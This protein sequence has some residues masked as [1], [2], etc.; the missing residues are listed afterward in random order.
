MRTAWTSV[1]VAG[2]AVLIVAA[3]LGTLDLMAAGPD[4][5]MRPQPQATIDVYELAEAIVIAQGIARESEQLG[6]MPDDLA[7]ITAARLLRL[8]GTSP[9]AADMTRLDRYRGDYAGEVLARSGYLDAAQQARWID[10]YATA[11]EKRAQGDD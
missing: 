1:T 9:P 10:Y 11:V 2:I 3:S 8:K 4:K 5:R 6:V 7:D